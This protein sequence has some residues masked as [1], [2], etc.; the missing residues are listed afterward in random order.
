MN[1]GDRMSRSPSEEPP[2]AF[3]LQFIESLQRL[4]ESGSFVATYKYALL[5]ALT[6]VAA[7]KGFDDS[8]EQ[9]VPLEDLGAQFLQIY[10]RHTRDYPGLRHPLRQN[11]GRQAAILATVSKAR[12]AV[13]NPDRVDAF[14]SVP[15]QLL[16]EATQRVKTMPLMKLQ[17]IGREKEDPYHPDNFLYPTEV[18][19]GCIVLN[20]GVSACLRRFR[21]LI[22]TTTQA[23]WVEYVR[24]TN[25]ELG[26]GHD[27]SA[28][29]FG[30]DRSEV[31]QYADLLLEL[32]G[33]RC[34]YTQRSLTATDLHV[35][36]FIPWSRFPLN[37]PF[38]LVLTSSRTNIQKSDHVAALPH[39]D[40]WST[41]NVDL[42]DSLLSGGAVPE[43][44]HRAIAIA[45]Y[46]YSSAN[47][48]RALGWL[49]GK[50]MRELEGWENLL[51]AV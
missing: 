42:A 21:P 9:Y 11:T 35:D 33:G 36:H 18:I 51:P 44:R 5:L 37:S 34:F 46:T 41:R 2:A 27:L 16:R 49:T 15:E 32:Q 1:D 10:W 29:L 17:T 6:N 3:Q 47:R 19:D 25:P 12:D 50:E 30:V 31:H 39:L 40:R 28:F 4:L 13:R 14:D 23:A 20:P 22:T 7:E 24:R 26:R 8:R 45:R 38:N 48:V 43:D